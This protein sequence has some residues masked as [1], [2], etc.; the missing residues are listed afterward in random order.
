MTNSPY[1]VHACGLIVSGV[2][3][4]E[5]KLEP[6]LPQPDC[7]SPT[8]CMSGQAHDQRLDIADDN[9]EVLTSYGPTAVAWQVHTLSHCN[10]EVA[11]APWNLVTVPLYDGA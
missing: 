11:P 7:S 6:F 4:W 8:A 5:Y 2:L 1:S 9:Q 10:R 3:A